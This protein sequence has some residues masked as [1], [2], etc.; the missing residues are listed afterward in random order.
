MPERHR[1]TIFIIYLNEK[2]GTL[3]RYLMEI[4][5][6]YFP[7]L[8]LSGT[9]GVRDMKNGFAHYSEIEG[10]G[11]KSLQEGQKVGYEIGDSAKGPRATKVSAAE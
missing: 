11:H 4:R 1:K 7:Q 10:T 9:S 5:I 3:L 2:Q 8:S 6:R